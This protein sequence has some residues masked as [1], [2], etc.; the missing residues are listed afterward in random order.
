MRSNLGDLTFNAELFGSQFALDSQALAEG[1]DSRCKAALTL[2][3]TASF[4][5]VCIRSKLGVARNII[6]AVSRWKATCM[7][8]IAAQATFTAA[9][10]SRPTWKSSPGARSLAACRATPSVLDCARKFHHCS[11]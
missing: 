9:F 10:R 6:W 8:R 7:T 1:N 3:G 11:L 2:A 4:A 5:M